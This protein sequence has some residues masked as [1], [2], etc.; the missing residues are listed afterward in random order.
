MNSHTDFVVSVM[1]K[2]DG[3]VITP[4]KYTE[5]HKDDKWTLAVLRGPYLTRVDES[6]RIVIVDDSKAYTLR[7]KHMLMQI[8]LVN[9]NQRLEIKSFLELAEAEK[10]MHRFKCTLVFVDNIFPGCSTGMMMVQRLLV[11]TCRCPDA[12]VMMSGEDMSQDDC[13]S[14]MRMHKNVLNMKRVRTFVKQAGILSHRRT[15]KL[16]GHQLK[17]PRQSSP[18]TRLATR[19]AKWTLGKDQRPL[20]V[21]ILNSQQSDR[22]SIPRTTPAAIRHKKYRTSKLREWDS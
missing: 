10:Y 21:Q 14:V 1:D 16:V 11:N 13:Q 3:L 19:L 6:V 7:L 5:Q 20:R 4:W 12:L 9:A 15:R 18:P 8:V 17:C 2:F 22:H